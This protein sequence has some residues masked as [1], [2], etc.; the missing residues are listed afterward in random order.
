MDE[1]QLFDDKV[2]IREM[3]SADEMN[4]KCY[5]AGLQNVMDEFTSQYN[6][7]LETR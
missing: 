1:P 6:T 3:L 2:V 7:W 5:D 4:Q